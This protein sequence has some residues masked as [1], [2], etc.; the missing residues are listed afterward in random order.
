MSLADGVLRCLTV[1]R[2]PLAP[3]G[4]L[5]PDQP[6]L[7][8]LLL[9]PSSGPVTWPGGLSLH[10][11]EGI[12]PAELKPRKCS[13]VLW[14]KSRGCPFVIVSVKE[15]EPRDGG[16]EPGKENQDL[17][18]LSTLLQY[19]GSVCPYSPKWESCNAMGRK[20]EGGQVPFPPPRTCPQGSHK[21]RAHCLF[22]FKSWFRCGLP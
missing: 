19:L 14:R 2:Q 6:A 15:G 1:F 7:L 5:Q 8:G 4:G 21:A 16:E 10:C 20:R 9:P 12:M 17:S 22:F 18:H 13:G 3:G 11:W